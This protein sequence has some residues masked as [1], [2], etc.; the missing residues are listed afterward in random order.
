MDYRYDLLSGHRQDFLATT[1]DQL[2]AGGEVGKDNN[3]SASED[4]RQGYI[5][6]ITYNYGEKYLIQANARYDGSYNFPKG[7]RW[8]FFPAFS[9]GWRISEESFMK[10]I[11]FLSNLKLRASWG[12]FGNDKVYPFYYKQGYTYSNGYMVGSTYYTGIMD[13]GIPNESI[14]W[15]TATNTNCG[16]DFGIFDGK[17]SGEFDYFYK[18][19]EGILITRNASVP[20]TFGSS[21]PKENL[22]I[23]DNHGI[24]ST[25][26]YRGNT[27]KL[28]Y[29][30]EGNLTY[31]TSKVIYIDEPSEVPDRLKQTGRPL[32]SRYGYTALGL[33]QTQEEIDAS[34]VQDGNGNKSIHPGDI[35]YL[36]LNGNDTI[37]DED[38][39]YIG[40]GSTPELIFG[41]NM[42]L[43]Y[44]NLSLI[45]NFQG[46][47]NYTR[48]L[49]L[50]S[51]EKNYNTYEALEDSWR[52]G[53]EDAKYPRLES[54]GRSVN[55]SQYSTYWLN[56]GFYIKMRNIELS[57][58]IAGKPLLNKIGVEELT[59][60]A[61]GR[62]LWTI[63]KKDGFDPE[64]TD[65][66]YPIMQT[67][68]LG[69]NIVF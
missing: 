60:S 36:D 39:H 47:S 45:V 15:E 1:I 42:K 5:G 16:L 26:R 59:I 33:F 2:F 10:N 20:M 51:F 29:E 52:V 41:L 11:G 12:Q 50:N 55:N 62:N 22:G 63:A 9:V 48:Y 54:N 7:E 24:E 67:M 3:G 34:P 56:D 4:A 69:L 35:K 58:S 37:D 57:Y 19:T 31:A 66:R 40:K 25:L 65:N 17:L 27:G 44:K 46:A 23:V 8:G 53:N 68:S 49:Y 14:T 38:R 30:V 64:G 28:I 13:T 43:Q 61:S 6:R 32:D 21:L 18:K